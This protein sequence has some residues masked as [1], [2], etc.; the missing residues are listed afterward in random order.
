MLVVTSGA[1]RYRTLMVRGQRGI[2]RTPR[3][4]NPSVLV[5]SDD[6]PEGATFHCGRCGSPLIV[7]VSQ[8]YLAAHPQVIL[9]LGTL[10]LNRPV[11][12]H[13]N[14]G[15]LDLAGAMFECSRCGVINEFLR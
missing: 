2:E 11:I 8:D 4:E 14:S 12:V 6:F 9:T 1:P 10:Y 13:G 5:R 15:V 7:G 3:A